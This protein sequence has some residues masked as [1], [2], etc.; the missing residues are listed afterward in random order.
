ML[1]RNTIRFGDW[2]PKEIIAINDLAVELELDWM[3]VL[4]QALRTYRLIHAGHAK[5]V[6]LGEL[7]KSITI[8]E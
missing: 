5:L 7:S 8:G 1:N 2:T 6:M 3:Q 4:R